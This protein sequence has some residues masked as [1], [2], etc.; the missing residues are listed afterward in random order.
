MKTTSKK[1]FILSQT[2]E[3]YYFGAAQ[4]RVGKVVEATHAAAQDASVRTN[5]IMI[6]LCLVCPQLYFNHYAAMKRPMKNSAV[7]YL[8]Q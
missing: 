4:R 3:G 6:L 7:S 5:K 8:H 2:Y 1:S